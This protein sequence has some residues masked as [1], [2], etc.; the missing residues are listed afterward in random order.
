MS[1]IARVSSIEGVRCCIVNSEHA[2]A[3][4]HF[5]NNQLSQ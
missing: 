3:T 2:P 1:T 4:S 5:S